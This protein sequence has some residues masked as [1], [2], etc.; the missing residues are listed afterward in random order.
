MSDTSEMRFRFI[1]SPI[2]GAII[3]TSLKL[4]AAWMKADDVVFNALCRAVKLGERLKNGPPKP[5]RP[6]SPEEILVIERDRLD[7]VQKR[8]DEAAARFN[9]A[10]EVVN[11]DKITHPSP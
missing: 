11:A 3:W 5:A 10:W 7:L 9:K 2:G 6:L 8:H 1:R 4:Q